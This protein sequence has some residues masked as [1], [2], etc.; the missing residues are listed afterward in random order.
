MTAEQR[1]VIFIG[2][3]LRS[4]LTLTRALLD[5]HPN[6]S[7]GPDLRV[8]PALALQWEDLNRT[9]AEVNAQFT[10]VQPAS[11]REAFAGVLMEMLQ[12]RARKTGKRVVAEK[13]GANVLAFAALHALLPHA[14]LVH[15]VRDGRDVVASM[16]RRTWIDPATNAPFPYTR[17]ALAAAQLWA[18]MVAAGHNA[19]VEA[20]LKGKVIVLKYE[21]L[22]RDPKA[23]LS[24]IL[25]RVGESWNDAMLDFYK[26]KLDLV[27]IEQDSAKEL[28]EPLNQ[29][30]IGRW[31][32]SLSAKQH[33]EI[34]DGLAPV[35]TALGYKL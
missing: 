32:K 15:V 20:A 19:S 34:I 30:G 21:A 33:K 22:I 4:G 23:A 12:G 31:R 11:V 13:T 1:P 7:C 14:V 28:T 6:I 2:G 25:E 16:L 9:N 35:M 24:P 10:G 3:A 17:D 29:R 27:G 5:A 8:T 18:Q 26:K